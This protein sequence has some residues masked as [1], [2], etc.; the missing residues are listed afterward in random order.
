MN[1]PE[2]THS[3][4]DP[5]VETWELACALSQEW[6]EN[7]RRSALKQKR[8]RG[9]IGI[10]LV[11]FAIAVLILLVLFLTGNIIDNS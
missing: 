6:A 9:A 3:S 5:S 11:V 10:A 8:L 4:G 2:Y 7:S 1:R